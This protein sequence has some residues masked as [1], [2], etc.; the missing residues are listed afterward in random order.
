MSI[1]TKGNMEQF[2][3]HEVM[4][5][6]YGCEADQIRPLFGQKFIFDYQY[7][8]DHDDCWIVRVEADGKETERHN[9]ARLGGWIWKTHA[10][11]MGK[12]NV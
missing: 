1:G 4:C 7:H 6:W 11:D 3:G 2:D 9:V 12:Q 5:L 10:L 8:G